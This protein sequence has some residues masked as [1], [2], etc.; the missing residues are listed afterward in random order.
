MTEPRTRY[1]DHDLFEALRAAAATE[2]EPLSVERYERHR[3]A[4]GGPASARIIQRLD[5]WRS[6]CAEAGLEVN[7]SLAKTRGRW[8]PA[9]VAGYVSAYLRSGSGE[10]YAGYQAWA[11]ETP[12][13]PSAQ[14]VRNLLGGWDEAKRRA[15]ASDT[16]N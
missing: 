15:R 13:A 16:E 6:A 14:T 5:S 12:E 9:R 8:D 3:R 7:P 10:S 2:G 1:S 11:R 4:R